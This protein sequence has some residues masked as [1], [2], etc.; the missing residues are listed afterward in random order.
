MPPAVLIFILRKYTNAGTLKTPKAKPTVPPKYDIKM[1]TSSDGKNWLQEGL[2]SIK[3]KKNERAVARPSVLYEN[4]IYKMWFCYE[5][6]V[7]RYKIGYAESK[8]GIDWKRKDDKANI[9]PGKKE[10]DNK[11]IAYP[12]V[13]KHKSL[14]YMFYSF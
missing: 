14:K 12:H 9:Y 4:R 13:I 5:K 2:T 8:N 10:L 11:M 3:L 1:A 7:G 6:K